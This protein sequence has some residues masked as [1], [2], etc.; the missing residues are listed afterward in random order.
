MSILLVV[1]LIVIAI[2]IVAVAGA[3]NSRRRYG[4]ALF[5]ATALRTISVSLAAVIA[6]ILATSAWRDAGR[7]EALFMLLVPILCGLAAA[8]TDIIGRGQA[9]VTTLAAV[10]MLWWSLFHGLSPVFFF[11]IPS[12]FMTAAAGVSWYQ[13]RSVSALAGEGGRALK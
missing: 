4:S 8:S 13:Q 12:L 3:A 6:G 2:L 9:V 7:V 5:L 1:A 10:A 11:I